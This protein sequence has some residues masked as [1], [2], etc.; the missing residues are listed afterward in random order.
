MRKCVVNKQQ[1]QQQDQAPTWNP[2]AGALTTASTKLAASWSNVVA[3]A[4]K[5]PGAVGWGSKDT[6]TA[7][8]I[9]TS[10][11][12]ITSIADTQLSSTWSSSLTTESKSSLSLTETSSGVDTKSL[13][14]SR[15]ELILPSV[16]AGKLDSPGNNFI[17]TRSFDLT[18]PLT[19][20]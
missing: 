17:I 6:T 10:S 7:S 4:A 12:T 15:Q 5:L 14:D 11:S 3:D 20:S 1:Q 18:A 19:K 13:L 16:S 8:N 9:I 2:A